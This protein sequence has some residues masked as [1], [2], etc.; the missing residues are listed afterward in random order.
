MVATKRQVTSGTAMGAG[1]SGRVEHRSGWTGRQH[2]QTG[3]G[4]ERSRVNGNTNA[5][6]DKRLKSRLKGCVALTVP[7][8]HL[9]WIDLVFFLGFE[10]RVGALLVSGSGKQE[11]TPHPRTA[12]SLPAHPTASFS[13]H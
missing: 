9:V 5:A 2:R 10:S 13:T 8:Q 11:S 7:T 1:R 6:T 12:S 4:R 3:G